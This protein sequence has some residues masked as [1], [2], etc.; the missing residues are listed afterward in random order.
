MAGVLRTVLLASLLTGA[1]SAAGPFFLPTG[2]EV[3]NTHAPRV[4]MD[5]AGGVHLA[6]PA[7]VPA[8]AFYAYCPGPCDGPADFSVVV[9]PT[10]GAGTVHDVMLALDA[11]GAPHVLIATGTTVM[12][13]S[14]SG[15]CRRQDAWRLTTVLDHGGDREVTGEAFALDPA[16][17]PRFVM[18]AYRAMFGIGAPEPGTFLVSCDGGCHGPSRWS[19]A[20]ISD[21]I[22]QENTLRY[23]A[24]G[25]AHLATVATTDDGD[26]VA[27]LRCESDCANEEVD[28]WPGV[29]LAYGYSDR[30]VEEIDPA[31]SLALTPD[32][33]PRLVLLGRGDGGRFLAYFAC[34]QDCAAAGGAAWVGNYLL[35]GD[36]GD[37]LDLALDAAGRPRIAY[38][39][40]GHIFLLHCEGDCLADEDADWGI[41]KVEMGSDMPP[42]LI[43]PYADCNVAAW[44]LRQPSLAIGADGLP[45]VAYRAEDISGGGSLYTPPDR[46]RC[47]AGAD[48]TLDRF[49]ALTGYADE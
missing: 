46:P 14:C 34:D 24:T 30:W 9:F 7:Y 41:A 42:D 29:G 38:T 8:D 13:A 10:G 4:E 36:I 26:L 3:Y 12:Y 18:H 5:A 23:D 35:D 48:M 32:G 47:L 40:A 6:Y 19:V 11:N 44:F 15:D 43:I 33:R 28:N 49:V 25:V 37:G 27:Y 2:A 17:R 21:Q 1:A 45:R 31:V 39:Y 20:K 16:G 22:W